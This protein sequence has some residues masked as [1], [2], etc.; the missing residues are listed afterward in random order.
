[1]PRGVEESPGQVRQLEEMEPGP[2]AQFVRG[3]VREVDMRGDQARFGSIRRDGRLG[4][5]PGDG[6]QLAAGRR[7]LYISLTKEPSE[8]RRHGVGGASH[9]TP[10]PPEDALT[11]RH[12]LTRSARSLAISAAALGTLGS[13]LAAAVPSAPEI[14]PVST[15]TQG[16]SPTVGWE[17]STFS[18]LSSD[19][20][21]HVR[22]D[23]L[24]TGGGTTSTQPAGTR[25]RMLPLINGHEYSIKVGASERAC[26][27]VFALPGGL[28][29]CLAWVG[30][31]SF[32]GYGPATIT[33]LDATNPVGTMT[34]A[35]GAA[36]TNTREVALHLN[37]SDPLSNGYPGSGIDGV[38]V[39]DYT[40]AASPG[41]F[42]CDVLTD[43]SGCAVPYAPL[44]P[45][46][47]ADGP[48]G[49]RKVAVRF[50]DSSHKPWTG[51]FGVLFGDAGNQSSTR[52]DTI[53]LDRTAPTAEPGISDTSVPPGAPVSFALGMSSDALAGLDPAATTWVFGDGSTATGPKV[54]HTYPD[55]GT[56]DGSATVYDRAGNSAEASFS[57]SV[58]VGA[59]VANAVN[60]LS[61]LRKIGRAR[62][63]KKM[64]MA[65]R[66]AGE[67][68]VLT[69]RLQFKRPDGRYRV[70][71]RQVKA[72][73]PG[74]VLFSFRAP[75]ARPY[76]FRVTTDTGTI[77]I[78]VRVTRR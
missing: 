20:T 9:Q 75:R 63:G 4:G 55:P 10:R 67:R 24:S 60:P 1:M 41:A 70:V 14:Y 30:A 78:P 37:G 13:G 35:G 23:D 65:V 5:P 31:V 77:A 43:T 74:G 52:T 17:A 26:T 34:I 11:P 42:A 2:R 8:R 71:R 39:K 29:A 59:T 33:R 22:V 56:Y 76:T 45:F 7:S 38:H 72:G 28:P 68:R 51:P 49:E 3:V 46:T 40:G 44:K 32:S 61:K 25:T 54:S 36:F 50:S 48:D 73:G 18:S 6:D 62:Q 57:I 16:S 53:V 27:T 47:L 15:F 21:Y 64:R 19:R 66:V 69:G 58:Q 12:P